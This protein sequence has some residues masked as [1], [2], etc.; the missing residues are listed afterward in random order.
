MLDTLAGSEKVNA[1]QHELWT[2][3]LLYTKQY[4]GYNDV[5]AQKFVIFQMPIL[6]QGFYVLLRDLSN[7]T[8]RDLNEVLKTRPV[9]GNA[10]ILS[11]LGP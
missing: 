2:T 4:L 10:D 7:W 6:L 1:L 5:I 3:W 11:Q 8:L 9:N